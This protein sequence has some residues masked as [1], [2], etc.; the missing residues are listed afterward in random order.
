MVFL[1]LIQCLMSLPLFVGVLCLSAF[2]YALLSNLLVLQ[3]RKRELVAMSWLS[4]KYLVTVS[5]LWLFL[6]VLWVGLQC[7]KLKVWRESGLDLIQPDYKDIGSESHF[8]KSLWNHWEWLEFQDDIHVRRWDVLGT[9]TVYW[10]S[11]VSISHGRQIL[12]NAVKA[13]PDM[14][15]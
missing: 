11:V 10:Q 4:S 14:T 2:C 13:L 7:F 6:A 15:M 8:G 1:F 5:V 3:L 9:D 12:R